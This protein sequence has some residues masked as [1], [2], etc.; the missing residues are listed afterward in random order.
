MIMPGMAYVIHIIFDKT[1][2]Y[3]ILCNEYCG[4]GHHLMS[5]TIEVV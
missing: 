1:G 3:E 5:A 4:S 2:I